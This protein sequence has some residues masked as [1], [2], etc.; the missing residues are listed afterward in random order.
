MTDFSKT[1]RYQIVDGELYIW[2]KNS[3]GQLGL[4]KM[5]THQD[6]SRNLRKSRV[7][8]A[9]FDLIAGSKKRLLGFCIR[10]ALMERAV[11]LFLLRKQQI[12]WSF[13]TEKM[14]QRHP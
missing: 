4:G 6:L 1:L 12:R 11:S 8:N 13:K 7:K 9:P 14:Q 2:G 10:H 3:N 5:N